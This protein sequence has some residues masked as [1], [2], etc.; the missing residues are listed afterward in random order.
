MNPHRNIS[1]CRTAKTLS[2]EAF[3]LPSLFFI[4]TS[5]LLPV[6]AAATDRDYR[7]ARVYVTAPPFPAPATTAL[8]AATI[9][10]SQLLADRGFS[11][12]APLD[13]PDEDIPTI[14]ID[15][16][17]TFQTI[18]G[19]GGAF[20]DAAADIFAKLPRDAQ[21][22]FLKACFDPV[23]GNGYTLCRTTIHS[24][25][26]AEDMYTY[27]DTA[28]DKDLKNFTID[29]DR[30]DRIPFI[31]R[32]QAVAG[33][34]NLHLY[35]S[36]W[37][38]PGWM[39]TNG[40]MLHGGKLK[41]EYSQTWADYYVK[42][43]KAYLAE[44]IPMWGLTV[45]N[46]A[47]ATQVWESSIFTAD[48]ERDFVRNFL[49]PTL[50]KAALS[51]VKLMIWDHNRGLIYE[52]VQPAYDDPKASRY[53]WGAAFHWYTGDHFDNVRIVHD[54]FP[55][56]HLLYTEGGIGG[57]WPAALRLSK[58]II[59]DLN[60]WTEGWDVWN[61]LLDQD[62]GPRH[63]GGVPGVHGSTIV[64]ANT[65]TGEI[66]YNPPHYILGQFSRFI[67]PGAKRIVSTSTSDDF[68]A[69]AALNSDG[70]IAVV[71]LNL[72]DRQTFL[73]V[74]LHGKFVKYQCPPNATIT[75]VLQPV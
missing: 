35:A 44:G 59:T 49:G 55:D 73:R 58:S 51:D 57:T 4:V 72:Q 48:E 70:K 12:L 2:L 5:C 74:W 66:T 36:P 17:K 45:Q 65:T 24:C 3:A 50:E 14:I 16:K 43:I 32:A 41:P 8:P 53:I 34:G 64:N 1:P 37:S 60:N 52:R 69:T 28:G 19:F 21:E 54:A 71:V 15:D 30:K 23:D 25:D 22:Q 39:K 63:A 38:P 62:N 47:L 67:R 26:Y 10:T 75:F 13:E 42:Y 31:K 18:Q 7:E 11:P 46:E 9:P 56:K 33:K 61:L 29:H 40:E 6:P 20:T 27:D 68:I